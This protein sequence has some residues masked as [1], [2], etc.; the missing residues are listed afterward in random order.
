MPSTILILDDTPAN[1]SVLVDSLAGVGYHLLVAEDGEDA[2]AQA[3][4]TSPD[5][6]LLDV[7]MPGLDGFETCRRLKASPATREIPVIFMTALSDTADKVRAFS[8]GA[9]D[10]VTKPFQQEEVIS[11]VQTHLDLRRLRRQVE[12]QLALRE[13][14]MR[15]AGHDLRN[16]LCLI[17][18]GAEMAEL[19]HRQDNTRPKV[20]MHL[21]SIANASVQMRNIIDTFLDLRSAGASPGCGPGRADM[22]LVVR[23]VAAQHTHAAE[24]KRITLT[25]SLDPDLPPASA[26][27]SLM[28][29]AITNY[30]GN[31]LKFTPLGGHVTVRTGRNGGRSRTEGV[32]SGPGVPVAER[33]QLFHE[34]ARLS[35]RPTGGE[36]SH[37]IGLSIVKQLVESQGGA[38]GADFPPGQ[39]SVFWFEF[40]AMG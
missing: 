19:A 13:R 37:G 28:F 27:S 15:I 24:R 22:N 20:S 39:G 17:L 10:Y 32:D 25:L 33:H 11:R 31:A 2:L 26:D 23:S 12:E 36:E 5:L 16:H 7:M 29:Q 1:L 8:A 6:I 4:H 40:P 34:N 38:V 35:V 3:G 21:S 9:V 30:L 18:L 14:F